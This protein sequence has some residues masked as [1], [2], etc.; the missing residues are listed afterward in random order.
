MIHLLVGDLGHLFVIIAFCTALV[1]TYGYIKS[2]YSHDLTSK[3]N[4]AQYG[5]VLFWIHGLAVLGVVGTL[6]FIIHNH[7]FEYHYAYSHT[8]LLLPIYY[9]ISSF[10]EGQ[11]GSF[12]LWIFW[13][14]ILG[15]VLIKTNKVWEAP[16]MAVFALVQGFL[17]SMILG[18]V[19][20]N[21]KLGS[22]P[23]ILLRDAMDAPIFK[24]NPDFVP[25]DGSGL[26]P[27]LQNY[28]MVIHPPTLFLGF[29][30]TLI[31][32]AYCI[33]GLWLGK[34]R[35]WVRPA[36]P[37]ALFSAVVLGVGIL[38]GAYWAYETLNFGGYWNWDPVENAVYVP[39][40]VLIAA[41]HTMI[42]FRKSVGAL[43]VAI[44]L[45][46]STFI[47]ILYSTFLT[48]SGI[49]GDSSVHSFT[50]LGLSGQLLIY[51][52]AFIALSVILIV[53]S[54]SQLPSDKEETSVYS[55]EFWI[56]IGAAVLCLM[57]FHVIFVT[58]YPVYNTVLGFFGIVS[59]LAP[60]VDQVESY[61]SI[62]I[63]FAICLA[64]LS[65]TGQFFWWKKMDKS[66]LKD[67]LLGPIVIALLVASGLI[68]LTNRI[69]ISYSL[70]LTTSVYSIVANGKIL[71]RVARSNFNLSGGAVTHIGVAL[72]LIG[73]LFSSG[74]SN[75]IS[76]NNT[77]L[78]WHKD[79]PDEVNQKNLLL[80]LNEPRQMGEYSL[81]YRGMR[82]KVSGFNNYVDVNLLAPTTD[83]VFVVAR[84]NLPQ[85]Q[86]SAQVF[87]RGDTLRLENHETSY[88]EIEYTRESGKSF[89]L[90]PTVQIN[91]VMNMT[92]YS[93]DISRTLGMDLYTH[94]RTFPDPEQDIEWSDMQEQ[95]VRLGETFFVNDFV[96]EL[97][98]VER[99]SNVPGVE[100]GAE[101]IA[102]Q[103]SI[104][105]KEADRDYTA[106]PLYVIKD[107]MAGRIPD[108][109]NDLAI[110]LS[111]L[112]ID[113]ESNSFT[114]GIN[115]T[116]K[117][118]VILEA[119]EKPWIN[120]LWLG[121]AILVL[122]FGIAIKRR[123][124]EFM[125]MRDKGLE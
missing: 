103:A 80:F 89:T 120:I 73:I 92:V 15:F 83:P 10:W 122:G 67:E 35:D 59:K 51:L 9:Q 71:L 100:L 22:S 60:P 53:R 44:I 102:V 96:A 47:L 40:I 121:T 124:A 88:F 84:E 101:D 86:E 29:A 82:K 34:F 112:K 69:S 7:Y 6:F 61:T 25:D 90:F 16:I 24:S 107:Q 108:V 38:M 13:N 17:V 81:N 63:W 50:D 52:L 11:E 37:W 115:T 87:Q 4:W 41:I 77:G 76:L 68:I 54:W 55:R 78:V 94:V 113:P 109:V 30:T 114:L 99:V 14:V 49:L 125:Q 74:Y 48:R 97:T 85:G 64:L 116:Q 119:V 58:S 5:R 65:G 20:F 36:L 3:Q 93:P 26:N 28:W 106:Q 12:L 72:M 66:A 43:K 105:I 42:A 33:A 70:L 45:T 57:G 32:F 104:V 91:P 1:S 118:W 117:D 110:R 46:I 19:I 62:Q 79:F 98:S 27:L 23:F 75:T 95:V 56:F 123:Y 18:V 39:W 2:V 31:P 8:S 21:V 111:I